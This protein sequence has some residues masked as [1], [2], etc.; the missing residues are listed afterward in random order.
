MLGLHVFHLHLLNGP[1]ALYL[2]DIADG[3]HTVQLV[4]LVVVFHIGCRQTV[5]AYP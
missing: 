1:E 3:E 5:L 4:E 2:L